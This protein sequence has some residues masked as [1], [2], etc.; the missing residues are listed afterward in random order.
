MTKP[1]SATI[2]VACAELRFTKPMSVPVSPE[3]MPAFVN[4]MSVINS[5]MPTAT[6]F[7]RLS[8]IDL[9]IA[10]RIPNSDSKINSTPS[11]NTAVS[12]NAGLHFIP[13]T[14]V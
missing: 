2:A 14:T 3:V 9:M 1:S 13:S 5:P 6:A 4:P 10:S 8:G 7:R 12:A 11:S